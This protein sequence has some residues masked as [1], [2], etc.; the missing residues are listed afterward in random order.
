MG[1][2]TQNKKNPF[3]GPPTQPPQLLPWPNAVLST[4]PIAVASASTDSPVMMGNSTD[5]SI[6]T[7]TNNPQYNPIG[8]GWIS[9]ATQP[10]QLK[11][12]T[13]EDAINLINA[14]I[15]MLA[16]KANRLARLREFFQ[17]LNSNQQD[18]IKDFWETVKKELQS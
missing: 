8:S 9:G 7:I 5:W 13:K 15:N 1:K 11:I 14:H 10:P 2:L 16:Q 12:V 17:S 4:W 6:G 18:L 3:L